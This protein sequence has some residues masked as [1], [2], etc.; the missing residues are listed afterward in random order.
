MSR[1]ICSC[2]FFM[3]TKAERKEYMNINETP[4]E[5]GDIS[6]IDEATW[7]KW[8]RHGSH[9]DNPMHKDYIPVTVTGSESAQVLGWSTFGCNLDLFALKTDMI[10]KAPDDKSKKKE[11]FEAGHIFEPFVAVQFIR[12]MKKEFPNVTFKLEKD[13]IWEFITSLK[14]IY[15]IFN[16]PAVSTLIEGIRKILNKSFTWNPNMM[17]QCGAKNPD[18]TLKYPFA[19][20]D[21]DGFVKVGNR[22]A[23]LE[24]KTTQDYKVIDEFK[25]GICP[26]KY[27]A[28]CRHSMAVMNMDAVYIV[29]CWGWTL[30]DM[31]VVCVERDMELEKEIMEKERKFCE[32]VELGIEPD[33][34]D[35][36][37]ELLAKFRM[38]QYGKPEE[39]AAP[40][41]LPDKCHD[42]II[43]AL[44]V[45]QEEIAAEEALQAAKKRKAEVLAELYPYYGTSDYC[46]F[47]L[48]DKQV[49]GI[50]L[51][52]PMKR[53][54]IDEEKLKIEEPTLYQ[55]Y[56]IEK[57]DTTAF[58]KENKLLKTKY[59][60][61]GGVN[62]D[63]SPS[64]NLKVRDIPVL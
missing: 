40:V 26:A 17:Y 52:V 16:T 62:T 8:R 6:Y 42:L 23:I 36:D 18:G 56:L 9:Y 28:Q 33:I 4:R 43:K 35:Q 30:N 41:E 54:T 51:K 37:P 50:K 44:L 63:N 3:P 2:S 15:P 22:W 27:E 47:R 60:K 25:K 24:C 38:K 39:T 19:I 13:I 48:N 1:C 32:C 46:S 55:K 64:Y 34:S 14:E 58:G 10:L 21:T 59:A 57:F 31:A 45:E 11:I 20:V 7:H 49:V 29:C 61:K 53:D 12:F 5:I